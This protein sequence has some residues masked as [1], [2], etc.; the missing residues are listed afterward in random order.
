MFENLRE[1]T[2]EHTYSKHHTVLLKL[3]R[4]KPGFEQTR[5]RTYQLHIWLLYHR[6]IA[7]THKQPCYTSLI[8][9]FSRTVPA[10]RFYY[11]LNARKTTLRFNLSEHGK[12]AS[13]RTNEKL[14]SS[15]VCVV[16]AVIWWRHTFSQH[17]HHCFAFG[18]SCSRSITRFG[19]TMLGVESLVRFS[20][21]I[22]ASRSNTSVTFFPSSALTSIYDIPKLSANFCA[23]SYV[24]SRSSGGT[25]HF[26][27]TRIVEISG[28]VE[29]S[30]RSW[31]L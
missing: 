3:Y 6:S 22:S 31:S 2:L 19:C 17:E 4:H 24:T 25:W 18:F 20:M 7:T 13:F 15:I 5:V 1:D 11:V 16:S 21:I 12:T 14:K 27:P 28:W 8:S 29:Y 26:V 30:L 9:V 10:Q 23:R